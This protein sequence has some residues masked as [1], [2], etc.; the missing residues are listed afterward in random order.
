MSIIVIAAHYIQFYGIKLSSAILIWFFSHGWNDCF[1]LPYINV[2]HI[3]TK[4][5]MHEFIIPIHPF[6]MHFYE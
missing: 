5:E 3:C 6:I 2:R 4:L 1:L